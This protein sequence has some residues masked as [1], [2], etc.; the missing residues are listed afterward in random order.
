VHNELQGSALI[1]MSNT[2]IKIIKRIR[3]RF[4]SMTLSQA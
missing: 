2:G 3:Q 1:M 4:R